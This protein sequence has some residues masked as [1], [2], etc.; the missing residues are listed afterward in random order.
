MKK[1]KT[2][3]TLKLMWWLSLD[4]V[5]LELIILFG[6]WFYLVNLFN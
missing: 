4:G 3:K 1:K 2:I 6:T 5:L